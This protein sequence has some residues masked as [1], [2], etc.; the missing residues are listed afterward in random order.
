M[1]LISGLLILFGAADIV[2]AHSLDGGHGLAEQ[3]GHQLLGLH[4]LPFTVLVIAAGLLALRTCY[5]KTTA[6]D[7]E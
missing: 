3:V 1:R 2:A 4:H 6:R 7:S 5:R